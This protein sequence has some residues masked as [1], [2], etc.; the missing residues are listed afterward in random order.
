[1]TTRM[2]AELVV[3]GRWELGEG[4]IWDTKAGELVF[5]DI[6]GRQ[7]LRYRPGDQE[8]RG[9]SRHRATSGRPPS[10]GVVV[11]WLPSRMGSG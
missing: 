4:P 1:M 3:D 10:G 11:S 7:V 2:T 6:P 9:R 5:V 8:V